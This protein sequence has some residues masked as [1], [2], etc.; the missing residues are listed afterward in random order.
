MT[1]G[2]KPPTRSSSVSP[3]VMVRPRALE[4]VAVSRAASY[5]SV[6]RLSTHSPPASCTGSDSRSSA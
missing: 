1:I 3:S 4:Y 2:A 6:N 5:T